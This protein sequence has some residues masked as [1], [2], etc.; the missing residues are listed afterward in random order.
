MDGQHELRHQPPSIAEEAERRKKAKAA[1]RELCDFYE[2]DEDGPRL[3]ETYLAAKEKGE[4]VV[5]EESD[6]RE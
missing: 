6:D 3:W 2:E 1:L 4:I 5:T